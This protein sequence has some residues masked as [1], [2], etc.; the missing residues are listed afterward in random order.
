MWKGLWPKSFQ[1]LKSKIQCYFCKDAKA[2][3]PDSQPGITFEELALTM[4]PVNL[5]TK[6]A[7]HFAK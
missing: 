5:E 6:M 7:V 1:I 4:K 2:R 3:T